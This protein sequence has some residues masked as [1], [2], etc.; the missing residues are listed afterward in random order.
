MTKIYIELLLELLGIL[1]VV[2]LAWKIARRIS[3]LMSRGTKNHRIIF[4]APK[5]QWLRARKKLLR[6]LDDHSYIGHP[7][8]QKLLAKEIELYR[9]YIKTKEKINKEDREYLNYLLSLRS[10]KVRQGSSYLRRIK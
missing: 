7:G 3:H 8:A 6:F 5:W 2:W 9:R 4:G 10:G 1:A